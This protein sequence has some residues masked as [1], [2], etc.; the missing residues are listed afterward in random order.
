MAR[1]RQ[2]TKAVEMIR[3]IGHAL[4]ILKEFVFW[5]LSKLGM[6]FVN[7]HIEY[8]KSLMKEPGFTTFITAAVLAVGCIPVGLGSLLYTGEVAMSVVVV[9][10]WFWTML[11][12][13]MFTLVTIAFKAFLYE[14]EEIMNRLRDTDIQ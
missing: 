5:V 4:R 1:V 3:E 2:L 12:Y 11:S 7:R 13:Y 10:I 9:K 6:Y 8:A 14:R